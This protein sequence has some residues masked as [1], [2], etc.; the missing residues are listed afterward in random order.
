MTFVF[1]D[2]CKPDNLSIYGGFI[3]SKKPIPTPVTIAQEAGTLQTLEGPVAY[4]AGDAILTGVQQERWRVT[5]KDFKNDY[6]YDESRHTATKKKIEV[7]AAPMS[8]VFKV[9]L[10]TGGTITG[11]PGDYLIQRNGEQDYWIVDKEIF[12]M[13]Y[14]LIDPL[15][16]ELSF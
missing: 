8:H 10:N 3:F 14:Q 9:K 1:G 13:T 4:S 7:W 11:K 15:S 2:N 16:I 5:A 6:T 12:K